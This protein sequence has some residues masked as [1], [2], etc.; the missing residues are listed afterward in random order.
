MA[1]VLS[2]TLNSAS[3]CLSCYLS[4]GPLK[5]DF[6]HIY[7]TTFFRVRTFKTTTP[8]SVVF[9]FWK[10]SSLNLNF[11]NTKK[12]WE[13][14]FCFWDNSIWKCC[15]ILSLLRR[16]HFLSAL[17]GLTNNPKIL[18]ITQRDFFNMNCLH[19]YQWIP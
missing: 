18:H 2:F 8:I 9:F 6:L 11:Q 1:K 15:Y 17:S 5:R 13:N 4:K 14:L 7:L 12:N 19:R 16:E 3:A 10:C